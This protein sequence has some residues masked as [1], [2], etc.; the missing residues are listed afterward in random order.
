MSIYRPLYINRITCKRKLRSLW[1]RIRDPAIKTVPNRQFSLAKDLSYREGEWNNFLGPIANN[2]AGRPQRYKL[3]KSLLKNFHQKTLLRDETGILHYDPGEKAEL[4]A[5]AMESPFTT[6]TLFSHLDHLVN[7]ILTSHVNSNIIKSIYF[8]QGE[9]WNII[10]K[11][12]NRKA[13]GPENISNRVLKHCR[14]NIT[15]VL[16]NIYNDCARL[17]YFSAP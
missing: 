13:L 9:V 12:S 6:L 15:T 5:D 1:Q 3:S 16:C 14:K 4:F 17:Q 10:C 8:S 11:L 7:D 2:P